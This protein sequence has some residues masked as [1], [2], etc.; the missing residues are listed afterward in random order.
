MLPTPSPLEGEGWGEGSR[1]NVRRINLD[2]T[3][4]S[5]PASGHSTD[6]PALADATAAQGQHYGGPPDGLWA[7]RAQSP[8]KPFVNKSGSTLPSATVDEDG[9]PIRD[10][11]AK[12]ACCPASR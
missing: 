4:L 11:T 6:I 7:C 3:S 9:M 8:A 10:I 5:P 1:S 12:P 2:D